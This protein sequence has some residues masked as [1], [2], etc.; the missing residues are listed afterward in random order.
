MWTQVALPQETESP[1][2][3]EGGLGHIVF[4]DARTGNAYSRKALPGVQ[5]IATIGRGGYRPVVFGNQRF[6]VGGTGHVLMSLNATNWTTNTIFGAGDLVA[7]GFGNGIF[8]MASGQGI[9]RSD[10]GV[11]WARSTND[12]GATAFSPTSHGSEIVHGNGVFLGN[13]GRWFIRSLDAGRSWSTNATGSGSI[14][15]I[16]FGAGR[17]VSI[18][19]S[20]QTRHSANGLNWEK[21]GIVN[22]LRP[23]EIVE[24]NR[25]LVAV[26]GNARAYSLNGV[27]WTTVPGSPTEYSAG[28]ADGRFFGGGFRVLSVSEPIITPAFSR[29]GHV[30]FFGAPGRMHRLESSSTLAPG[31]W[32][33]EGSVTLQPGQNQGSWL[34]PMM[35]STNRFYR[36]VAPE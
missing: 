1:G 30:T 23:S 21:G 9:W 16:G 6:V 11:T 25:L 26:G 3:L 12:A 17:F 36:I 28:F 31:S 34:T 19:H 15:T 14:Y 29:T 4:T 33:V 5:P 35:K 10:D 22:V 8:V 2:E 32:T 18:D 24:G 27:D 20:G 13:L 7:G